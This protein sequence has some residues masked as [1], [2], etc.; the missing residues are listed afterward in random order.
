MEQALL[1]LATMGTLAAVYAVLALGLNLQWGLTGLM[2]FGGLGFVAVG[3]YTAAILTAAPSASH[4][5]GFALPWWLAWPAGAAAGALL[6]LPIG[7]ISLRLRADYLAIAT[8]GIAEIVRLFARNED[9]LTG[10]PLGVTAIPRPLEGLGTP[11]G[12]FAFLALVAAVLAGLFALAEATAR[13]PFGRALRAVRDDE[14]AA[15]A[16]GKNPARLRLQAF[17]LGAAFMGLGGAMM[18]AFFKF[19]GP[20]ALEPVTVTFLV[21]VMLIAGGSGNNLGAVVGAVAVWIVWAATDWLA[22]Q[23]PGEL[24]TRAAYVRLFLIGLALQ[25]ILL[26]RPAGLIGERIGTPR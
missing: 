19:I 1:Y 9:W 20:E 12:Q 8:I 25:V 13:S 16:V 17:V 7:A 21:W 6:A 15:K 23:L 3:A 10:G 11:V 2:N 5:G 18:A 26:T 4:L 22:A 24:A 14:E